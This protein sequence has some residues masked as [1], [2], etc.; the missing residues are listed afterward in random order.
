MVSPKI[1]FPITNHHQLHGAIELGSYHLIDPSL[2]IVGIKPAQ[3]R[4]TWS[5]TLSVPTRGGVEQ[6]GTLSLRQFN[7]V[8]VLQRRDETCVQPRITRQTNVV[9]LVP[10]EPRIPKGVEIRHLTQPH[11]MLD[12]DLQLLIS[13]LHR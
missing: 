8:M 12:L 5:R 2:R 6:Q 13:D 3:Q 9:E 11:L 1:E 10:D 7:S 4:A